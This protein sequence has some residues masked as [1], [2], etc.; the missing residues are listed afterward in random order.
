M[1]KEITDYFSPNVLSN[2][3]EEKF[4]ID[5]EGNWKYFMPTE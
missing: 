3:S 5:G 1:R 2:K 4:E